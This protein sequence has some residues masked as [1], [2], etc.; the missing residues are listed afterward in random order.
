M[1]AG[2][3]LD[4]K[5][6]QKTNLF[7]ESELLIQFTYDRWLKKKTFF[8]NMKRTKF[9]S[10]RKHHCHKPQD[11]KI[12][13][14]WLWS[15]SVTFCLTWSWKKKELFVKFKGTIKGHVLVSLKPG[16]SENAEGWWHFLCGGAAALLRAPPPGWWSSSLRMVE[17][18]PLSLWPRPLCRNSFQPLVSTTSFFGSEPR[19]VTSGEGW[20]KDGAVSWKLLLPAQ[21]PLHHNG[22][23]QQSSK[24]AQIHLFEDKEHL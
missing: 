19:S 12:T 7:T 18:L 24:C 17:L 2:S 16:D 23:E 10:F 11:N 4:E 15:L 6:Q 21:L 20:N 8:R 3:L 13:A 22:P 1:S 9:P 5:K 14:L